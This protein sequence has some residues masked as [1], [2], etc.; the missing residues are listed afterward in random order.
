MEFEITH[1]T[2]YAYET[3]AAEA[4][5]ELRLAPPDTIHQSVLARTLTIDPAAPTSEYEDYFGNKTEFFSLPWRHQSLV[6]INEVTV[7]THPQPAPEVSL[8]VTVQEA[9]QIFASAEEMVFDYLL[10]TEAIGRSRDASTWARKYLR[11]DAP[12]GDALR[13]LNHA[14]HTHFRYESGSTSTST[15]LETIWKQRRGVCQDF[16]HIML[17]VLRSAG[18]PARYV[19]GYIETDP[20]APRPGESRRKLVGAVATHAWVEVLLPGLHWLALDPTNDKLCDERH[21]TVSTGRDFSDASPMRGTFKGAGRQRLKV[22]VVM[23]R[24]ATKP[25]LAHAA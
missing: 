16:S 24:R 12:L 10:A 18:L 14:V 25:T 8:A 6:V 19:C 17:S 23:R 15:S 20:P 2:D 5:L 9:R 21:V 13:G 11:G 3:P 22:K 1:V 7:H 4:Y